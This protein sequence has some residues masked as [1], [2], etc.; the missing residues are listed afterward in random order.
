MKKVLLAIELS[1]PSA[2]FVL[3]KAQ[4]TIGP[5]VQLEVVH[6]VDPA[7]MSYSVDP[8]MT[9]HI[10]QQQYDQTMANARARMRELCEPF[11]LDESQLH[12][13]Y[14]RVAPQIHDL[15][16]EGDFDTCMIGSHGYSGWRRV[17]GSVAAS[18]LHGAP[19][20]TLVFSLAPLQKTQNEHS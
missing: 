5:D 11:G 12:V 19:V 9:G 2:E 17:L 10:Y 1:T 16:R 4:E 3:Q 15:L 18:V 7:S 8:S 13:R 6:V 14:G 20:N